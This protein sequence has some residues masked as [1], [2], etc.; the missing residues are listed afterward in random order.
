M[1]KSLLLGSAAV[2]L[3]AAGP[4][5]ASTAPT[6]A[7]SPTHPTDVTG[8]LEPGPVAKEYLVRS[9]DGTEWGVNESDR[10]LRLNNYVGQTVTIAGD[11]EPASKAERKAGE[12]SHY[13]YA[14][15]VMV[16]AESCQK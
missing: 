7:M 1:K 14:R 3:F 15:D 2:F 11:P 16:A 9:S 4:M 8:C 12:A 13:L 10:D 6:H 5:M